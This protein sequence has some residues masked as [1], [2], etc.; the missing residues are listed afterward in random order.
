MPLLLLQFL[1]STYTS[2]NILLDKNANMHTINYQQIDNQMYF[3]FLIPLMI[4]FCPFLKVETQYHLTATATDKG[5]PAS[6]SSIP[7]VINI[8][9]ENDNP[10]VFA[11]EMY[12]VPL[13]EDFP[14][15]LQFLHVVATDADSGA[16]GEF[17]Y[18]I[19]SGNSE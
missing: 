17:R 7:V 3:Y 16:A 5:N 9:D 4:N 1:I 14:A 11:N 2:L 15:S 8:D 10:P 6:N 12:S 19:T 18:S 13:D